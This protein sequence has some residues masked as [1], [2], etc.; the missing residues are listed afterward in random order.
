MHQH[1]RMSAGN[2]TCSAVPFGMKC[3]PMRWS[4]A[5]SRRMLTPGPY[6]RSDSVHTASRYGSVARS[7]NVGTRLR[8]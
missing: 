6:S 7:S 3:P 4:C 2:E 8:P 5:A 1:D